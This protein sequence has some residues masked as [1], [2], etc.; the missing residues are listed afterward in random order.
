MI[1]ITINGK[2]IRTEEGRSILDVA[3]ELGVNIP[4]LCHHPHLKAGYGS[5][6]I[7]A[8]E[9]TGVKRL[10][11]ACVT[12]V[13]NNMEI[14]TDSK[15]VRKAR[16][17]LI[18]L[19]L[20]HHPCDCLTC[21]KSGECILQNL[22]YEYEV[23]TNT[24]SRFQGHKRE[25][26]IDLKSPV[27]ERN[28][29][30]CITCGRCVRVCDEVR[31]VGAID[32]V[33][34]G[35]D[36]EVNTPQGMK[37]RCEFCGSC[38]A[39]CPVG[40]LTSKSFK[41]K[42]RFW[43]L[44]KVPTTCAY[45]GTG[46]QLELNV[47]DNVIY[48][49]TTNDN[50]GI[51]E[52]HLCIR[53][54]YGFDFVQHESRL[55]EPLMRKG[56]KLVSATWDEVLI[57]SAKEIERI[58]EQYGVQSIAGIGSVRTTNEDNYVFQKF[59][60]AVVGTNNVDTVAHY[61]H[62]PVIKSMQKSFGVSAATNSIEELL[63]AKVIV[64]IGLDVAELNPIVGVKIRRAQ[65][66]L[67]AKLIVV[68]PKNDKLVRF[69]QKYDGTWVK[70]K[71]GTEGIL[72]AGICNYLIKE[73]KINLDFIKAHTIGYENFVK[74]VSAWT[75]EKVKEITGIK[76]TDLKEIAEAYVGTN[77]GMIVFGN[78]LSMG[79]NGEN[80]VLAINNLALLTGNIGRE[81]AGVMPVTEYSNLQG[82]YDMG[83]EPKLLPGYREVSISQEKTKFKKAWNATLPEESG[84][85]LPEIINAIQE[86]KIKALYIMGDNLVLPYL[87]R[88]HKEALDML[89]LIIV[90]DIYR[91]ESADLATMVFPAAS[92][93]EKNG[94]FTNTDRRIQRI[95]QAINRVGCSRP[96]WE[97]I[98]ALSA[99]MG[100]SM[101]FNNESDVMAEISSLVQ[102][103]KEVNFEELNK[104]AVQWPV[105]IKSGTKFLFKD[106]FPP[107][108]GKFCDLI[109]DVSVLS[110]KDKTEYSHD[111]M[112]GGTLCHSGT[113]TMSHRSSDISLIADKVFLKI[114]YAD[115]RKLG[116]KEND[117]IVLTT[118]FDSIRLPINIVSEMQEGYVFLP[119]YFVVNTN[120][121]GNFLELNNKGKG[122]NFS[123]LCPV[124][125]NRETKEESDS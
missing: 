76:D 21:D 1:D 125:L 110:K 121:L 116:V 100:Y 109:F 10:L 117:E 99:E 92:F 17:L 5:C 66:Y 106:G 58:K 49:V 67:G 81:S 11:P 55:K 4:T 57:K 86:G 104:K 18:E 33:R 41:Y 15:S 46:C 56:D 91:T 36:T 34:R 82:A 94:T 6:R 47:K 84:L 118:P 54:R 44:K 122:M 73:N 98:S 13:A 38:I 26:T 35:F 72:L 69:S 32:Y 120:L 102:I 50:A 90:Q 87:K 83:V 68:S 40:A 23:E 89:E 27:I 124:N 114:S 107:D 25:F 52:G 119:F 123:E 96:D 3:N 24:Y 12:Q 28:L 61:Y 80:N 19:L 7:C 97:I 2:K 37:L 45:C 112:V 29:Y 14:F 85:T 31:G 108:S 113:G 53:G 77:K 88:R 111:L 78:E 9:I 71:P 101:N 59:F 65:R 39:M 115:A 70:L 8:V 60:R 22:A 79:I 74:S 43:E 30:R 16:K 75:P 64:V 63:G 105:D 62:L 20:L 95:N 93:A 48:R 51:N 42:A 103:Y